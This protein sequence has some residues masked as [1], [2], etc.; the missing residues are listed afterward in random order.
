MSF[1]RS[2]RHQ[3]QN[4]FNRSRLPQIQRYK[5]KCS[6]ASRPLRVAG[7]RSQAIQE[8]D[9][10]NHGCLGGRCLKKGSRAIESRQLLRPKTSQLGPD[11]RS[12]GLEPRSD[13]TSSGPADPG[14]YPSRMASTVRMGNG[15]EETWVDWGRVS[16]TEPGW[17]WTKGDE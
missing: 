6:C 15:M 4:Q 5:G 7:S 16:V 13:R 11:C 1:I 10:K 9:H 12:T 2:F 14:E 8:G 17:Q 3:I